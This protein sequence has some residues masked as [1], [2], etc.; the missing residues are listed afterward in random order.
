MGE[1]LRLSRVR[2]HSDSEGLVEDLRYQVNLGGASGPDHVKPVS[3]KLR[4]REREEER[5]RERGEG[6]GERER[7]KAKEEEAVDRN[8]DRG[9][10]RIGEGR[11]MERQRGTEGE[12]NIHAYQMLKPM[13]MYIRNVD[14]P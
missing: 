11:E 4:K 9:R 14:V 10:G 7:G 6:E 2:P 3:Q 12:K 1:E 13:C 5:K 8:R